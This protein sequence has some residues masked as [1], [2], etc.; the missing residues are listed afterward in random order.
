M[1]HKINLQN[2]YNDRLNKLKLDL[3]IYLKIFVS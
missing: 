3:E 2:V 1:A